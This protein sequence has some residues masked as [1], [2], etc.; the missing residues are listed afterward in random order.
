MDAVKG[1]FQSK[2]IGFSVAVMALGLLEQ[3]TTVL[4]SLVPQEYNGIA[5]AAIGL[6]TAVLRWKTTKPLAEK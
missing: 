1:A 5:V 2:T 3:F 6:V 4:P